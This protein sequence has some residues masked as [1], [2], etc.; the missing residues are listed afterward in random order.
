[1]YYQLSPSTPFP[2][3]RGEWHVT[4]RATLPTGLLPSET[5]PSGGGHGVL[6]LS[7]SMDLGWRNVGWE[8]IV[9]GDSS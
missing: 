7:K 6:G 1:M 5:T 8:G 9:H 4:Y 2:V 3:V